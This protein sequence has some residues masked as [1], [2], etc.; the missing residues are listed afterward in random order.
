VDYFQNNLQNLEEWH[1]Y[2]T[3][4]YGKSSYFHTNKHRNKLDLDKYVYAVVYRTYM[5]IYDESV[6]KSKESGLKFGV[7]DYDSTIQFLAV[8][9]FP[10]GY[11]FIS[12]GLGD[13]VIVLFDWNKV[14]EIMMFGA[15]DSTFSDEH[16]LYITRSKEITPEKVKN[17]T[18][19][20]FADS[21]DSIML[22]TDGVTDPFFKTIAEVTSEEKWLAFWNKNFKNGDG[23]ALDLSSS[24][25]P[26]IKA[27]SLK[28]WLAFDSSSDGD[29]RTIILIK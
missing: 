11:F 29:D 1:G 20:G 8:K 22:A 13:G 19:F 12:F 24:T 18:F 28:K 7:G 27:Q 23:K 10:F 15:P 2:F 21:F 4:K 16:N 6:A 26:N 5:A 3:E 14:G 17:K 25:P 9:M